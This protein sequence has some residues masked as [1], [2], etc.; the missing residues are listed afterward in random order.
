MRTLV[1]QKSVDRS[2][3]KV[4][5]S[6]NRS[7][8]T[9]LLVYPTC[10]KKNQRLRSNYV[11]CVLTVSESITLLQKKQKK[12]EEMKEKQRKKKEREM[13]R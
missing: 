3:A 6:V 1:A 4:L 9:E 2:Q 8:L 13:K 10:A 7:P 11:A 5:N 12:I